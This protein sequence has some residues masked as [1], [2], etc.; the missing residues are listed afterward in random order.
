[1]EQALNLLN[2]AVVIKNKLNQN[3]L[4][5]ATYIQRWMNIVLNDSHQEFNKITDN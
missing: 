3:K 1:M 2:Y 5:V 4:Q